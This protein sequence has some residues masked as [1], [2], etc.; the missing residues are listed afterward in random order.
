MRRSGV[1]LSIVVLGACTRTAYPTPAPNL[2]SPAPPA[3]VGFPHAINNQCPLMFLRAE[4]LRPSELVDVLGQQVP[5]RLPAGFGLLAGWTT[6]GA[7]D[8]N[9]A[10]WVDA[11]CR[12]MTLEIWP[13]AAVRDSPMP[14]GRW[15]L[16]EHGTCKAGMVCLD[17]RA[18]SDGAVVDLSFVGVSKRD[19]SRVL[20]GVQV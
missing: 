19:A 6:N 9:G 16:L 10:I 14:N 13:D 5:T 3:T 18:H 8:S 4:R 1:L 17:Y 7:G 2:T 12:Q 15:L 11:R 20:S